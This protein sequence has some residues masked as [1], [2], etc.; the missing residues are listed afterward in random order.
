M[1]SIL[2]RKDT[3]MT[4]GNIIQHLVRFSVTLL[5]GNIFQDL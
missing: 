1:A 4:E 5:I 3:N 2:N